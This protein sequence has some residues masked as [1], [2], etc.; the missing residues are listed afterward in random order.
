MVGRQEFQ[1]R[2]R[3]NEFPGDFPRRL[4]RLREASGL[5]WR[6]LARELG[7]NVRALYRWRAGVKPGAR[8]MLTLVE[9][10]TEHDLLDCLL[11]RSRGD[12]DSRQ[13]LLFDEDVWKRLSD[14]Q[15]GRVAV[16][17]AVGQGRVAA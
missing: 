4:E 17:E 13:A 15:G 11:T 9:F 14:E 16:T 10:A 12:V 5:T 6:G 7:V 8:H 1:L 2:S 3:S